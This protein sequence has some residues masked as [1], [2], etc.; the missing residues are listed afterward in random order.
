MGIPLQPESLQNPILS[1]K[2]FIPPTRLNAVQRPRLVNSLIQTLNLPGQFVLI[3]GPAGFGKTTLLSEVVNRLERSVAWLSVD[4]GDNDPVRFWSYVIAAIQSKST[5]FGESI[6][7]LFRMGQQLPGFDLAGMFINEVIQSTSEIILIIDDFQYI[8]NQHIHTAIT[9]LIEHLP[10]NLH[11]LITTRVDPPWPL[12]RL[13]ARN[14]IFEIRT[15]DLRFTLDE[16][17]RFLTQTMGLTIAPNE[18]ATLDTRTEGWIAG[19]QL[20]ALSL[21]KHQDIQKFLKAFTGSHVFVADYLMEEVLQSQPEYIQTFLL[22]TSILK[23]VNGSLADAIC[24]SQNGKAILTEMYRG[25]LFTLALDDEGVWYR[26]HQL[27]SDLLQARLRQECSPA[28]INNLHQKAASWLAE[29]GWSLEAVQHALV[30]KN[31]S[32]VALMLEQNAFKLLTRGE[33][34]TLSGWIQQLPEDLCWSN[35]QII[36]AWLWTLT[37][38]GDVPRVMSLLAKAQT[39]LPTDFTLSSSSVLAGNLAAIQGF[40]ATMSGE[41]AKA[42]AFAKTAA[43]LLPEQDVHV[44]WLL[45]YSQGSAFRAN[46]ELEKSIPPF[47]RL[48]EM[49]KTQGNLII[50]ATGVTEIAIVRRQQ[51]RLEEAKQVCEQA[52]AWLSERGAENYGSLAK[53]EVPLVEVLREQNILDEALERNN[54]ILQ[55]MQSWPMPTDRLFAYLSKIRVLI[56]LGDL[57]TATETLEIA[58]KSSRDQPV[59]SNLK[60]SLRILEARLMLEK[61]DIQQAATITENIQQEKSVSS[62]TDAEELIIL[63]RVRLAQDNPSIAESILNSLLQKVEGGEFSGIIIETLLLLAQSLYAQHQNDDAISNLMKAIRLAE[64]SGYQRVFLDE[65]AVMHRLLFDLKHSLAKCDESDTTALLSYV[66]QLLSLFQ[67]SPET[68]LF[69]VTTSVNNELIEQ[70]TSRELEVLTLIATG[71]SNKEV[72]EKLVI[73]LS[74]VKK[75]TANIYG[76]LNVNSRTQAIVRARELGLLTS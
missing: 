19:L 26:Y 21:Q 6:L 72:A 30:V 65:G 15:R 20:A 51:G 14:Q 3:S 47:T 74:A 32:L 34:Q 5:N 4:D 64:V 27:F 9:H 25:N 36:V 42:L 45:P 58:K 52:I 46:G 35:P 2:I 38:S 71:D 44:H 54:N 22:K 50:W 59:L 11:L 56:S 17:S 12:A 68:P 37:L 48:A 7:S 75:H 18:V 76:K 16:A 28:Q 23:R 40:F 61:G 33:L 43:T 73:S 13:R 66:D 29:N 39:L 49:G 8:Q 31:F 62:S 53:L 67:T 55:R 57:E 41:H 24:E 1:T 10:T 63:A 69:S 70:L 60:R